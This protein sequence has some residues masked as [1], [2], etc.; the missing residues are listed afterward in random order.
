MTSAIFSPSSRTA[1]MRSLV[2]SGNLAGICSKLICGLLMVRRIA[3]I[4]YC[5][6]GQNKRYHLLR[7]HELMI[8]S[9]LS[10]REMIMIKMGQAK[11]TV[12]ARGAFLTYKNIGSDLLGERSFLN[13]QEAREFCRSR[14]INIIQV[15]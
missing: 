11:M 5:Y 3:D 15:R 4:T 6:K 12:T 13:E 14:L 9:I 10:K 8:S 1:L 2:P 7:S